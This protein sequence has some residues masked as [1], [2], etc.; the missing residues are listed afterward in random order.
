MMEKKKIVKSMREIGFVAS[1]VLFYGCSGTPADKANGDM[2]S[3]GVE[4]GET[5]KAL[6]EASGLET[7]LNNKG[8]LWTINDS[9]NGSQVFL[10]DQK[11]SIK[12]TCTL[13]G[14]KNRDWEDIAIGPGP[15]ENKSYIYVGDI[16]DNLAQYPY[17]RI[18]RFEEPVLSEEQKTITIT[19]FDTITF[20]LADGAKDSEALLIDPLTKDLFIISKREEPVHVYKLPYP[21]SISDTITTSS[22]GTLPLTQIVAGDISDNGKEILLKNYKNVY[23]WKIDKKKSIEDI[24]K[25]PPIILP[26]D[27]EPQG[28]S[29]TFATDGTGYFTISEKITGEKSFLMFYKRK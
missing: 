6:H 25:E 16:G 3:K 27:E 19:D 5:H 29:I 17:K 8:F 12:L 23:Y 4:L 21:Q 10:V 9:N 24:L 2:F 11:L 14:V 22:I 18:Y 28:E 15:E 7:S 13:A 26:Y 1:I 20:R